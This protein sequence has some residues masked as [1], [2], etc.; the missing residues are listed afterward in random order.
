MTKQVLARVVFSA[1]LGLASSF[2]AR[3]LRPAIVGPVIQPSTAG[4]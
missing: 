3:T 4:S 1:A 2:T